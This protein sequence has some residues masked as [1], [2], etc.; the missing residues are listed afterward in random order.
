MVCVF[1]QSS[2]YMHGKYSRNWRR[3]T[4][5]RKRF[6]SS[7]L[8]TVRFC[9][10]AL[11]RWRSAVILQEI[12]RP[13]VNTKCLLLFLIN[14][15][16]GCGGR[17][18]MPKAGAVVARRWTPLRAEAG[19]YR[20][21]NGGR[22]VCWRWPSATSPRSRVVFSHAHSCF[23]SDRLVSEGAARNSVLCWH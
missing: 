20:G 17:V 15:K 6:P 8:P 12:S 3:T 14:K 19:S 21:G 7:L 10:S 2:I 13:Q 4:R 11:P 22:R 5:I 18:R 16:F 9:D 1:F 23:Y